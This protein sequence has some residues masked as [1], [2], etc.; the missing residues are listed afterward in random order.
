M[1]IIIYFLLLGEIVETILTIRIKLSTT[2]DTI[3]FKLSM[4]S[5]FII[6]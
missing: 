5:F 3:L 1:V 2:E 6:C 4:N